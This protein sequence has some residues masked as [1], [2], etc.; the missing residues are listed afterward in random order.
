MRN[1]KFIIIFFVS[2]FVLASCSGLLDKKPLVNLA[3][4]NYYRNEQEAFTAIMG[5]YDSIRRSGEIGTYHYIHLGD[6]CSDDSE[7]GN[8]RSDGVKWAG[9]QYPMMKFEILS[10]NQYSGN[11]VWNNYFTTVTRC[12]FA[13]ENIEANRDNIPSADMFIAEAVFLRSFAYFDMTRQ[14]GGLP[15]VDHVLTYEE[16]YSPRATE[17]DTWKFVEDGFLACADVLPKAW[18]SANTGRATKGA[19]LALLAR[20]YVYHASFLKKSGQDA[21]SVWQKAYD[22]I[23]ELEAGNYFSLEENYADIFDIDNQFG[24]ELCFYIQFQT[25]HTG[26]G[27]ANDGNNSAFYGHGV[28]IKTEDLDPE[29]TTLRNFNGKDIYEFVYNKMLEEFP[30][31]V[32]EDGSPKAYLKKWTGWALHCPTIDLVNAFEP[33]DPRLDATVIAPNEYYDGHTHF[34]LASY[35]GYLS[36]KEYVPF[37]NRTEESNEDDLPRNQ[38]ILRWGNVLLYMAEACAELN[39]TTEALDYLEMVRGRARN[40]GDDPAALPKVTET[41]KNALLEHIYHERRVEN[42]MEYDRYFDLARTGRLAKVMKAYYAN[43]GNDASHFEKGKA[44]VEGVHERMPIPD[45]AIKASSFNGVITL[46]QNP[47]Y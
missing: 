27:N 20:T 26:W 34:N 8:S 13:I 1:I 35:S 40:S 7:I 11:Y 41:D 2:Y 19:A 18:D 10:T 4:E 3:A 43:Y 47:G 45:R 12:N 24:P 33:G 23:K 36:K 17:E 44:V 30:W 37:A 25:S 21:S 46:E 31:N 6:N 32:N 9:N 28:G 42:A 15:I 29:K 38:I 39:K 14:F 5:A 16:Y 22:V